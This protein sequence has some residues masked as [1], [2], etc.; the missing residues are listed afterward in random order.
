MIGDMMPGSMRRRVNGC[1]STTYGP[2]SVWNGPGITRAE[3]SFK[4]RGGQGERHRRQGG[5]SLAG[6]SRVHVRF[7]TLFSPDGGMCGGIHVGMARPAGG[8]A[9][10]GLAGNG[11]GRVV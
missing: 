1:R 6:P 3:H 9:A 11:T 10:R 2:V 7:S 5:R 8:N 4:I